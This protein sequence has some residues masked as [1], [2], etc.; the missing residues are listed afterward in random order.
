MPQS[1]SEPGRRIEHSDEWQHSKRVKLEKY[2]TKSTFSEVS[3]L[4]YI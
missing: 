1:D 4:F 3:P 2:E